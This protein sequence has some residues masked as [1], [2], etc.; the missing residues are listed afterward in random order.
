M[1]LC[2]FKIGYIYDDW[3]IDNML[4]YLLLHA[5]HLISYIQVFAQLTSMTIDITEL[6]FT[7]CCFGLVKEF[8]TNECCI[9][10]I[11]Q[12][13]SDGVGT[14][15]GLTWH[16]TNTTHCDCAI[17]CRKIVNYLLPRSIPW[18]M[19]IASGSSAISIERRSAFLFVRACVSS[20]YYLILIYFVSNTTQS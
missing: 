19:K 8:R 11:N 15:V 3:L 2:V 7:T 6:D 17:R 5:H 9:T 1:N 13:K 18:S 4:L 16:S 14:M 20:T 10:A 12:W